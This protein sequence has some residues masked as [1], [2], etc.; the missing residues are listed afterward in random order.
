MCWLNFGNV[1]IVLKTFRFV[2]WGNQKMYI[3]TFP[4]VLL[5]EHVMFGTTC[6]WHTFHAEYA[7]GCY[8]FVRYA[9]KLIYCMFNGCMEGVGTYC[10]YGVW[11]RSSWLRKLESLECPRDIIGIFQE[12]PNAVYF[13]TCALCKPIITKCIMYMRSLTISGTVETQMLHNA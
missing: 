1:G 4:C 12:E 9:C 11:K 7:P 2:W 13:D 6:R 10:T 3:Y 8:V 5:A